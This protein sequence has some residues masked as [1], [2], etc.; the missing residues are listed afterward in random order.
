MSDPQAGYTEA[1]VQRLLAENPGVND[2][3]I[4]M[5]LRDGV[6]LLT[7]EVATEQR[8]GA[9]VALVGA[10]FPDLLVRDEIG[11]SDCEPP[12]A[13]PEQLP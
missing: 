12:V 7:G 11:V 6:L 8:R 5:S 9:I 4:E 13:E 2:Q 3:G 10:N 1:E